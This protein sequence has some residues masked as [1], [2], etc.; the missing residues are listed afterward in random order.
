M[1]YNEK[2]FTEQIYAVR[3]FL[4]HYSSY[5][6][7]HQNF[8]ILSK[9][10]SDEFWV[11]TINAHYFQAINLWCMVFGTNN[12]EIH[13]KKLGLNQDLKTLIM[14][15][16]DVSEKD[17]LLYWNEIINWRNKLSAHRVPNFRASVP[18]LKIA[19]KI[20]FVYEKWLHKNMDII[21]EFSLETYEDEYCKKAETILKT[22]N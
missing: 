14:S 20:V 4:F 19:R 7:L 21:F 8:T 18:D 13:W 17:Y 6:I 16:L 2:V 10:S 5:R 3:D 15:E 12:N 11:Y 1:K 22:T 9:Q